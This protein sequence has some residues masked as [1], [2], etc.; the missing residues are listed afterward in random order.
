MMKFR[1]I[2]KALSIFL[3]TILLAGCAHVLEQKKQEMLE[4]KQKFFWKSLRWKSYS[5]ALSVI[6]FKN[7]ARKAFVPKGLKGITVTAYEEIGSVAV[8]DSGDIRTAVLF[9][10]I[11]DETGRVF[12]IEH[13]ELWWYN[14]DSKQWFL[15]SDLPEFKTGN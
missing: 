10:Y 7:P 8:E 1:L 12:Q 14:E 15:D 2:V 9:D 6:K 4:A 3:I 11:Q 13:A 5:S